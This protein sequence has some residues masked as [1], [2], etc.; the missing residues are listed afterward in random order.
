LL[1]QDTHSLPPSVNPN[2]SLLIGA[3][4][5]EVKEGDLFCVLL[6]CFL[7]IIFRPLGGNRYAFAGPCYVHNLINGRAIEGLEN[8]EYELNSYELE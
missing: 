8:G 5:S 6:G 7:S 3:G 2:T 1:I 4:L